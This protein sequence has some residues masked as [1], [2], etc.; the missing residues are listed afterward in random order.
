MDIDAMRDMEI[1]FHRIRNAD[2][3]YTLYYDETNNARKLNVTEAGLN[4]SDQG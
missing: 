4:V 2:A 1:Q 3:A